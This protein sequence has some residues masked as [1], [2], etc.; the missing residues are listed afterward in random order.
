MGRKKPLLDEILVLDL[1]AT[2]WDDEISVQ[3]EGVSNEIIEIGLATLNIQTGIIT[4]G[5]L[6]LVAPEEST[7]S[8]FCTQLTTWKQE[9]VEQ[10]MP[11]KASCSLLRKGFSSKRRVF[12]SW[13]NY[14]RR[15]FERQC[16]RMGVPYPFGPSHLNVKDLFALQKRLTQQVNTMQA[17]EMIGM[18]P[19]GTW[20]VGR[21]DA[22]NIARVLRHLLGFNDA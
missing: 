17:M 10:G 16:T 1:E 19:V 20:H 7:V 18:D 6:W 13:G 22:F 3:P 5:D 14:D 9:D 2:C 11:F 21:D 8:E 15:Q 4:R 12:A